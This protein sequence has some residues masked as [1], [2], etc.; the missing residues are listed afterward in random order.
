MRGIYQLFLRRVEGGHHQLDEITRELE[1]VGWSAR[2]D[3]TD[4]TVM[5]SNK[6][7]HMF[8]NKGDITRYLRQLLTENQ[9]ARVEVISVD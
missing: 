7:T 5:V 8:K 2:R 4:G 9:L 6:L 1:A 3:R